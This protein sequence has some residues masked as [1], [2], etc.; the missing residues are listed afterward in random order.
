ML[1][2]LPFSLYILYFVGLENVKPN[3]D[4]SLT[5]NH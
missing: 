2:H 4:L 5:I 3:T 1:F